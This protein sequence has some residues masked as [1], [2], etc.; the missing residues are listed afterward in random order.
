M[1][2]YKVHLLT[3]GVF[4][5]IAGLLFGNYWI[6][7]SLDIFEEIIPVPSIMGGIVV[8]VMLIMIILSVLGIIVSTYILI[9]KEIYEGLKNGKR[10]H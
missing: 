5:L 10:V 8:S 6:W 1:K 9:Y 3:I 7:Y 2:K 4:L